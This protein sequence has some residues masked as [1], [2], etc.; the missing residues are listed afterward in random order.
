[1]FKESTIL[2]VDDD[3]VLH[4]YLGYLLKKRCKKLYFAKDGIEGLEQYKRYSPDIVITDLTMPLMN[5]IVMSQKIKEI[6]LLQPIVL[7]TGYGAIE[8]LQD[9]INIGLNA[10]LSKPIKSKELLYSTLDKLLEYAALNKLAEK[11]KANILAT[12]LLHDNQ[13]YINYEE[14]FYEQNI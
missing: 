6:N 11:Q 1:M 9:A 13:E 7:L 2:I 3:L 5:G 14:L 12:N 8:D 10:F 4:E